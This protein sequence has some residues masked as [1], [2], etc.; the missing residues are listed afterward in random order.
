MFSKATDTYLAKG[1]EKPIPFQSETILT[2]RKILKIQ[3]GGP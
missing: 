3:I 2:W 1:G